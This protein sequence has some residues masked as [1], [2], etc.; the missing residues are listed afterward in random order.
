MPETIPIKVQQQDPKIKLIG[1]AVS[2][3]ATL[4]LIQ[5]E[6]HRNQATMLMVV[7]ERELHQVQ[8]EAR[9]Q[10]PMIAKHHLMQ[11]QFLRSLLRNE[12]LK[13]VAVLANLA[14][15]IWDHAL[16]VTMYSVSITLY[17]NLHFLNV[18]DKTIG[19]GTFGKVKLGVHELT[20][21]RVAV[22]ILEKDKI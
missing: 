3:K 20:G 12:I 6:T 1:V 19:K 16:S 14:H 17:A 10:Q 9:L 5:E 7:R 18:S 21:E 11:R 15:S 2:E 13:S 4:R 22:K 8:A